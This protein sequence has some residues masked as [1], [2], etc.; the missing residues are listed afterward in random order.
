ML[1]HLFEAAGLPTTQ[2]SLIRPHTEH[3]RP[4]RALWVPFILGRPLGQPGD[5][6]FQTR[7]LRAALD[8][9]GETEGPV[10][11]DHDEDASGSLEMDGMSCPISWTPP[12]HDGSLRE[13]LIAEIDTLRSW[14]DLAIVRS[15]RTAFGTS[16][17]NID[18]VVAIMSTLAEGGTP[19]SD[20]P[21]GELAR[22]AAEDLKAWITEAA[23]AQP[24]DLSAFALK[25][26]FWDQ[27]VAGEALIAA[28]RAAPNHP[29]ASYRGMAGVMLPAEFR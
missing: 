26:W 9:F 17:G 3:I 27:T 20:R 18:D 28:H 14:Y 21:L 6:A 11:V 29:D 1:A 24:G 4:P 22:L 10:L 12:G 23:A 25:A 2:I 15:N 13:R 5:A 19:D 16:G 7:V 8:L